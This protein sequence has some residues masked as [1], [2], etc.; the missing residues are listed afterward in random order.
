MI[1]HPTQ[2]QGGELLILTL[3]TSAKGFRNAFHSTP[4]LLKL[5]LLRDRIY[6]SSLV[7]FTAKDTWSARNLAEFCCNSG[8]KSG[9][10][11]MLQVPTVTEG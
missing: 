10:H 8:G 5:T 7:A 6:A 1:W 4:S 9:C 3:L 11:P 2:L